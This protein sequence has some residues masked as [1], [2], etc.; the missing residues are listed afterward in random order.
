MHD[1]AVVVGFGRVGSAIGSAFDAFELPYV[2]VERDRRLVEGLR[3]RGL[4]VVYG[5]A[6][7]AGYPGG[8]GDWP[9]SIPAAATPDGYL[10]RRAFEIAASSTRRSIRSCGPT[11]IWIWYIWVG[12]ALASPCGPNASSRSP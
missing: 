11:A 3:T 10:A 9:G 6:S 8:G 4:R 1:H 5:D 2:V 12:T 7:A